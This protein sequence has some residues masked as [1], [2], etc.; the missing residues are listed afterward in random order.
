MAWLILGIVLLLAVIGA[1][2]LISKGGLRFPWVQFYVKGKESGFSFREVNLLRKVAVQNRLKNPAALFWSERVLDR[3]IRGT[4]TRF[5]A[6]NSEDTKENGDFLDQLFG[7]RKRV[8]FNQPKYRLGITS[9]RSITAG[10]PLKITFPGGRAYIST[11][12]ENIRRYLAISYPRGKTLP[13]GFSWKGKSLQ[14]YF[15]RPEDAGYYFESRVIGDYMDRKFPILHIAHSDS[16][17]RTQKRGSVRR[18]LK[19]SAVLLP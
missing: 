16:L 9:S 6:T 15:W 3:C 2:V 7:F 11:V 18:D 1:A 17:V 10:Q 19:K 8:E 12:V 4:I 14:I 5:R 13:P